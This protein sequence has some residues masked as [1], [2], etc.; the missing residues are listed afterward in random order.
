MQGANL[1]SFNT[2]FLSTFPIFKTT[3]QLFCHLNQAYPTVSST[4]ASMG[5]DKITATTTTTVRV[6]RVLTVAGSDS[7]AGAGIQAD[8]KA[9][10][11]LGVYC[12][13][14]ITAVTAQNT[15]GVQGI[16]TVPA[17][18][19]EKQMLSVLTDIGADVVKTGM[20]P[21]VDII[22]SICDVLKTYPVKALVVDPV[23]VATSGDELAGPAVLDVLRE[24]LL[25]MAD[26]VTPN[27][28]EASALIGGENVVN[29]SDMREA[30][31]AIHALGP[32]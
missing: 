5:N 18:F 3:Q 13:T 27:L 31:Q 20:L 17:D 32:R 19:V 7:G 29:I 2:N 4:F 25:P 12:T 23:L 26:L 15:A 24:E 10:A 6:P 9:C 28:P 1:A 8:M 22:R 21:T 30:A 11:A 16:H 14:V